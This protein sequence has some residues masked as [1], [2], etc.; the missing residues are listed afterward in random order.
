MQRKKPLEYRV[1]VIIEFGDEDDY[2]IGEMKE[3]VDDT[4]ELAVFNNEQEAVDFKDKLVSTALL[5]KN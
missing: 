3:L 4:V 1:L 5:N 2:E